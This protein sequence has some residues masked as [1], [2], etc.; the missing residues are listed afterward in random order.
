MKK[1]AQTTFSII[2]VLLLSFVFIQ[3]KDAKDKVITKFLELQVEQ[4]NKQCPMDI[5]NGL[6][7][8]QC[9]IE[10][11]KTLKY[12]FTVADEIAG[13]LKITDEMKPAVVQAIKNLPELKQFEQFEVSFLYS[14]YDTNKKLLGEIKVT[15]ED[16]K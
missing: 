14:Y 7:M 6:T 11:N 10:G 2:A 13:Q 5:G 12:S 16:Y 8:D 15:P 1:L 9:T 3:C 4:V